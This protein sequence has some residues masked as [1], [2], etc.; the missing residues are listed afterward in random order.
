MHLSRSLPNFERSYSLISLGPSRQETTPRSNSMSSTYCLSVV[1]LFGFWIFFKFQIVFQFSDML[2]TCWSDF[3]T[4]PEWTIYELPDEAPVP[5]NFL[6]SRRYSHSDRDGVIRCSV[7]RRPYN[8]GAATQCVKAG[9]TD[10]RKAERFQS[11]R[12]VIR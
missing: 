1:F 3:G 9:P 11:G 5:S 4:D 8:Q 2:G 10:G 7:I 12:P 6:S